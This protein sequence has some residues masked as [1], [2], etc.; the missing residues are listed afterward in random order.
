MCMKINCK[1]KREIMKSYYMAVE[2]AEKIG[3]REYKPCFNIEADG[4]NSPEEAM[5]WIESLDEELS[6]LRIIQYWG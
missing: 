2:T 5:R 3:E 6:T 1:I 4:F